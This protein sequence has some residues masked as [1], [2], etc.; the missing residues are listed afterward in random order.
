[1]LSDTEVHCDG[2]SEDCVDPYLSG[3]QHSLSF[4]LSLFRSHA[5]LAHLCADK[6]SLCRSNCEE[7][8][9]SFVSF[10]PKGARSESAGRPLNL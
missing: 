6:V 8:C 9:E 7:V 4:S 2:I 3:G 10:L 5:P 1:M